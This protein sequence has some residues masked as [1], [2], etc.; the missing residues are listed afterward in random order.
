MEILKKYFNKYRN[1]FLYMIFGFL[2]S[3]VNIFAYWFLGHMIH[4]PYLFANSIAWLVS[5]LFSFFSNKSWVFKS[6][7]STL[8]EFLKE[9]ISFMFSRIVSF[10]AD[11]FLMILGITILGW[12]SLW[13]KILDQLLVGLLNYGTSVLVFNHEHEKMQAAL[14]RSKAHLD[15]LRNRQDK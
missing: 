12:P 14:Q 13:V 4:M 7:Y 6:K 5:V 11:N 1:F 15:H 10:F 9:F 2:A 3:L 8:K